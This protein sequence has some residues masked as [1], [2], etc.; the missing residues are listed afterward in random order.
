MGS[1]RRGRRVV[2]P[3]CNAQHPRNLNHIPNGTSQ[4]RIGLSIPGPFS[5]L[6]AEIS[7]TAIALLAQGA[8]ILKRCRPSLRPRNVVIDHERYADVC[9]WRPT[10]SCASELITAHDEEPEP[11]TCDTRSRL[12]LAEF[13]IPQRGDRLTLHRRCH[14]VAWSSSVTICCVDVS[15]EGFKRFPPRAKPP[16]DGIP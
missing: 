13:G 15:N 2:N 4:W 16:R 11:P 3:P 10:A 7:A 5:Y 9:S 14:T 12:P 1:Q 6:V 8:E